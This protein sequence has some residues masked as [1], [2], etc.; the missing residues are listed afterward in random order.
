MF[1]RV[2]I[3]LLFTL[4]KPIMTFSQISTNTERNG[5][6]LYSF[7]KYINWSVFV[8]Q[9][10]LIIGVAGSDEVYRYMQNTYR[11]R[12]IGTRKIRIKKVSRMDAADCQILYISK[13]QTPENIVLL[14]YVRHLQVLIVT[15]CIANNPEIDIAIL[16][17]GLSPENYF[18]KINRQNIRLKGLKISMEL[19]GLGKETTWAPRTFFVHANPLDYFSKQEPFAL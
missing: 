3:I 8:D 18:L 15:D 1:W 6:F 17:K 9:K 5:L 14:E 11:D 13:L 7:A 16:S 19:S 10:A 4:T 12:T 2:I